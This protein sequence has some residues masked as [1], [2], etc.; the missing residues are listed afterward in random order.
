MPPRSPSQDFPRVRLP[1]LVARPI[2]PHW[3]L[4]IAAQVVALR[5]VAG[6]SEAL[7][8]LLDSPGPDDAVSALHRLR[9]SARRLRCTMDDLADVWP[10]KP[11]RRLRRELTELTR[12]TGRARDL[13]VEKLRWAAASAD[14]VDDKARALRWLW[15]QADGAR[16]AEQ[17]VVQEAL[18]RAKRNDLLGRLM[19][20]FASQPFDLDSVVTDDTLNLTESGVAS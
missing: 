12:G 17:P 9:V 6:M 14:A 20:F 16:R 15:A 13:D 10:K 1:E 7:D 18:E 5:A 4:G 11:L 19:A 3:P 2:A 8:L